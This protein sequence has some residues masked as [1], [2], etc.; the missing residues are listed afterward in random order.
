MSPDLK[1]LSLAGSTEG[2]GGPAEEILR[3]RAEAEAAPQPTPPPPQLTVP[4]PTL[5]PLLWCLHGLHPALL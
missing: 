5:P 3:A 1:D 4:H 2:G